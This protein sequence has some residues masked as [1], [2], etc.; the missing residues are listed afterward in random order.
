MS[1][2]AFNDV[3]ERSACLPD[4]AIFPLL[5]NRQTLHPSWRVCSGCGF[6]LVWLFSAKK[7]P[8]SLPYIMRWWVVIRAL[9]TTTQ[10]ELAVRSNNVSARW[11]MFTFTSLV[12]W[13]RSGWK[14]W[15]EEVT[16]SYRNKKKVVV[17][18]SFTAPT[19]E[20]KQPTAFP[21]GQM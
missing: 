1:E 4:N 10:L 15:R 21:H 9:K 12:Q 18:F 5:P 7:P 20:H 6:W 11:G 2:C 14:R 19:Q 17:F 16:K 8:T 13:M 3:W